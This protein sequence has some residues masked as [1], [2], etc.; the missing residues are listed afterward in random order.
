MLNSG[1]LGYVQRS[2]IHPQHVTCKE[3]TLITA[4]SPAVSEHLGHYVYLLSDPDTHKIFYVGKG[5]GNRV[6]EHIN[7]AYWSNQ[8]YEKLDLIRAIHQRGKEVRCIIH[9]HGLSKESAFEVE[10]S[11][12]D[13]IGIDE[14]S[15]RVLGHHAD[16]R[17][18]MTIEQ[19]IA[20]YD[21]P[22][23]TITDRVILIIINKLYQRGIT[24]E[25]LYQSTRKSWR[26]APLRHN[27]KYAFAVFR[28][29]VRQVYEIE[30]WYLS[31]DNPSRWEFEGHVA[32]DAQ[33]YLGKSVSHY[34]KRGAQ[35]P[36]KYINC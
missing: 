1:L 25:N 19:V 8:T 34:L 9:R 30:R 36:T 4:F 32:P 31:P 22:P 18:H 11:L 33:H 10:S 5:Q 20:S 17:G 35:R 12:I 13:F 29:V 16:E 23:I 14:L 27:P 15:N 2:A 24:E 3:A 7:E 28:G 21:A 26:I 6:F